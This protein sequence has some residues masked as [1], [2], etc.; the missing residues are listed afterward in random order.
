MAVLYTVEECRESRQ[1]QGEIFKVV[2][3]ANLEVSLMWRLR[4]EFN[5]L[6]E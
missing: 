5:G 4:G 1:K 2:Q 3:E 6:F